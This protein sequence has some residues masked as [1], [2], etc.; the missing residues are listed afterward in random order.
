MKIIVC[1]QTKSFQH[2]FLSIGDFSA[3]TKQQLKN[4]RRKSRKLREIQ[5]LITLTLFDYK[6]RNCK[7]SLVIF[8]KKMKKMVAILSS[9]IKFHLSD[10]SFSFSPVARVPTWKNVDKIDQFKIT[11]NRVFIDTIN[12][13]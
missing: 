1:L 3:K 9:W 4:I 13:Y 2:V 5:N 12:L 10:L 11:I 7:F 8:E 6:I